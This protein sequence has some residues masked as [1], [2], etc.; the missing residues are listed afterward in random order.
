MSAESTSFRRMVENHIQY[1]FDSGVVKRANHFFK[2]PVL[3]AQTL[4]TAVG[5][6]GR[7]ENYWIVAPIIPEQLIGFWILERH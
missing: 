4:Q 2:L 5:T 3:F 7:A 6:F 1:H